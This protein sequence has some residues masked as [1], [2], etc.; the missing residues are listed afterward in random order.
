MMTKLLKITITTLLGLGMVG[1]SSIPQEDWDKY[2]DEEYKSKLA[3]NQTVNQIGMPPVQLELAD[4]DSLNQLD[5]EVLM[6]KYSNTPSYLWKN[7]KGVHVLSQSSIEQLSSTG[8]GCYI[9]NSSFASDEDIYLNDFHSVKGYFSPETFEV[10][11]LPATKGLIDW[12]YDDN[13]TFTI[14]SQTQVGEKKYN[15]TYTTGQDAKIQAV[16]E[17]KLYCDDYLIHELWHLYDT[18]NN[19]SGKQEFLNIYNNNIYALGEEGAK[20]PSEFFA[21]AGQKYICM[22]GDFSENNSDIYNYFSQR[23]QL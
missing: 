11:V 1:C 8:N 23:F 7:C 18:V 2:T 14:K 22:D 20:S 19:E 4:D 5:W 13:Q 10:Y 6:S 15:P 21:I 17:E 9:A 12:L 3:E 16:I